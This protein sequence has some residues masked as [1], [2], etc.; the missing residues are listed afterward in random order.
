MPTHA[1]AFF[2]Y[3]CDSC[4]APVCER[5]HIMNLALGLEEILLCVPC[6]AQHQGNAP[7]DL[8]ETLYDYIQSRD[9]F[10]SPWE[11]NPAHHCPHFIDADHTCYCLDRP[12]P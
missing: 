10:K 5:G 7:D 8:V 4:T 6:L 9:C 11:K 12:N 3:T 2:P 1:S